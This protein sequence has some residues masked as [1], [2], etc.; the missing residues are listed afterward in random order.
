MVDYLSDPNSSPQ[1]KIYTDGA[2]S[3]NPG[4]GGYGVV[5]LY[6]QQKKELSGAYD[7]TT[8]NRMEIMAAIKGLE[9]LNKSCSVTIYTDS[10]Y[11]VDTMTKGW[12]EKWRA[13]NWMRTKK[14]PAKNVDLW[15]QMLQLV[16]KHDVQWVWV[17]GHADNELNNRC[18]QLAVK[19]I[20]EKPRLQDKLK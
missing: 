20:K 16:D 11:L 3:G 5:M 12:L 18:D 19:A 4:P 6:N 15:Q 13:K 14:E 8:N 10:R 2:C 1:V 7:N 17:K 9:A